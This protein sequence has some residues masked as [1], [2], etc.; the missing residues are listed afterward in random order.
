SLPRCA[1]KPL[2]LDSTP[3]SSPLLLSPLGWLHHLGAS[4][5]H[6]H[7]P[8]IGYRSHQRRPY[9]PSTCA[10]HHRAAGRLWRD[11]R[12]GQFALSSCQTHPLASSLAHPS[13]LCLYKASPGFITSQILP[14]PFLF[15]GELYSA[16]DP[17]L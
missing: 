4:P 6:H 12:H 7:V 13:L 14:P 15:S 11:R 3:A 17:P 9:L 10:P 2:P 8:R 1:A 16:V 5:R